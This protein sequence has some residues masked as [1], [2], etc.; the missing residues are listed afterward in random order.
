MTRDQLFLSADGGAW[1][2]G[3]ELRGR[4]PLTHIVMQSW[5]RRGWLARLEQ[6]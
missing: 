1:R 3:I 5:D 4:V 2:L 6:R